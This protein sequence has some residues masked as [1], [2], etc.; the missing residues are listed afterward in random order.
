MNY[1][2]NTLLYQ[3]YIILNDI[4]SLLYH[5]KWYD[6]NF[7]QYL[8]LISRINQMIKTDMIKE[9]KKDYSKYGET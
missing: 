3:Y 7:I 2:K 6:F 4:I 1:T 5:I 8:I 9:H